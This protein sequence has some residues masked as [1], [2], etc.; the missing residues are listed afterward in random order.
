[1]A[2]FIFDQGRLRSKKVFSVEGRL[3]TVIG[4]ADCSITTSATS[5]NADGIADGEV[6]ISENLNSVWKEWP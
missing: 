4:S 6:G 2:S 5:G 1:M 3:A